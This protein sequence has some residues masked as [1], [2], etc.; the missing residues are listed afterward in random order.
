MK[1]L[2]IKDAVLIAL[3]II[4]FYGTFHFGKKSARLQ[5]EK[6]AIN[7]LAFSIKQTRDYN[8]FPSIIRLNLDDIIELSSDSSSKD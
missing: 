2:G 3:V 5:I 4:G 6:E 7:R 8:S 1:N